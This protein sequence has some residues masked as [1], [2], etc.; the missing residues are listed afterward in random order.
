[1]MTDE[2]FQ[3]LSTPAKNL[4]YALG[5]AAERARDARGSGWAIVPERQ[6]DPQT[7]EGAVGELN[8]I[9]VDT[10]LSAGD[11]DRFVQLRG[12]RLTK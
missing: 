1:M 9:G 10:L 6:V 4:A 3:T 7:L 11:T 8:A 12:V 2:Q 5:Q